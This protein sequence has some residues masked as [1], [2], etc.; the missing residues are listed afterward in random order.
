MMGI[1]PYSVCKGIVM[2]V[3]VIAAFDWYMYT[4]YMYMWDDEDHLA[5]SGTLAARIGVRV[6]PECE[7]T[8]GWTDRHYMYYL[9]T[10]IGVYTWLV[11]QGAVLL[12][13][14]YGVVL[15]TCTWS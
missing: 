2:I 10:C 5:V 11:N 9:Y 1:C 8:D 13:W 4:M 6:P 12:T 15:L 3:L 14:H 7:Q